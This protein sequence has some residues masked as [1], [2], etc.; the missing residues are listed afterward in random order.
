MV[1][2]PQMPDPAC[3]QGDPTT[4]LEKFALG[5]AGGGTGL[6]SGAGAVFSWRTNEWFGGCAHGCKNS[7][8]WS[9][10]PWR[11]R[12]WR[13]LPPVSRPARP[14]PIR[15]PPLS[16]AIARATRAASTIGPARRLRMA[17]RVHSVVW[18][19]QTR[20]SIR[21]RSWHSPFPSATPNAWCGARRMPPSL[22]SI[23]ARTPGRARLLNFPDDPRGRRGLSAGD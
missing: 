17:L 4:V 12:C 14:L 16:S 5:Q 23:R 2:L 13:R 7:Y 20:R 6:D 21:R 22:P 8:L 1:G 15:C 10:S 19:R 11:C 9:C 18:R 3:R